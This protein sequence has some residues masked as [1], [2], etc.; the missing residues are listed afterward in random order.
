MHFYECESVFP[1]RDEPSRDMLKKCFSYNS[2]ESLINSESESKKKFLLDLTERKLKMLSVKSN[3]SS[4][5][6]RNKVLLESALKKHLTNEDTFYMSNQN[7]EKMHESDTVN[8]EASLTFS[9]KIKSSPRKRHLIQDK[10]SISRDLKTSFKKLK[11]SFYPEYEEMITDNQEDSLYT[12]LASFFYRLK[13]Q[14]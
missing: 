9:D 13:T 12:D 3:S 4:A 1:S 5:T 2:F 10:P 11:V 6:L 14:Q 8:S 7:V